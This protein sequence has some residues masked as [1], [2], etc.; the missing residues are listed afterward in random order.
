MWPETFPVLT[1]VADDCCGIKIGDAV[2][3]IFEF[4]P[5]GLIAKKWDTIQPVSEESYDFR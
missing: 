5:S 4:A 2:V 1:W 3:E